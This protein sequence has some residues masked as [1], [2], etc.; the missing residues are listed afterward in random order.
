MDKIERWMIGSI[1]LSAIVGG[2]VW[3]GLSGHHVLAASAS[4]AATMLACLMIGSH[5]IRWQ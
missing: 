3:S 1:T 5:I 4:A 2:A